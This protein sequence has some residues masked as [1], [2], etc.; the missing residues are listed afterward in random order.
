VNGVLLG[1][2]QRFDGIPGSGCK[3]LEEKASI[4]IPTMNTSLESE[5]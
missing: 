5:E 3:Q 2:A 1:G 4:F